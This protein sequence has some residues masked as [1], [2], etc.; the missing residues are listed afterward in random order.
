MATWH[1]VHAWK[2]LAW[3]WNE[4]APGAPLK[5]DVVWHCRQSRLTLLTF[6]MWGLGPPWGTW[7]DWQPSILIGGVFVYERPLLVGVALEADGILRGGSPHLLGPHRAVHVV[8]I[9]ALDQPLIHAM[10]EG[11]IE[12]GLLLEMAAVA[13]LGL[14]L[15][16][17]KFGRLPRDA[18]SGRR[19]SSHRSWCV[20]ELMAF[21]CCGPPAWQVRQRSLISFVET[22][23]NKNSVEVSAGSATWAAPAP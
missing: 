11:H 3:L 10:M 19:C 14:R 9:A 23:S 21:M 1:S 2:K 12:L 20:S 22:F 17:Q 5:L 13:K 6:S 15:R 7:Q 16:E 8:A 18:A 4:G